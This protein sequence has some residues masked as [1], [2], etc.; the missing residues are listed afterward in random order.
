MLVESVI[1]SITLTNGKQQPGQDMGDSVSVLLAH[2]YGISTEGF[3]KASFALLLKLDASVQR[4]R[5]RS[6][7]SALCHPDDGV[8]APRMQCCLL[9]VCDTMMLSERAS[10]VM[11]V[12]WLALAL[13]TDELVGERKA[14]R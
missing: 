4:L 2:L 7:D 13:A 12:N 14:E 11:S 1:G 10:P 6:D 9:P 3:V 8:S 5:K